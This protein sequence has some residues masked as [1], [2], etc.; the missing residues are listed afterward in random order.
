M[1]IWLIFIILFAIEIASISEEIV[2]RMCRKGMLDFLENVIILETVGENEQRAVSEIGQADDL[3]NDFVDG[4]FTR[5][6]GSVVFLW[7]WFWLQRNS[8]IFFRLSQ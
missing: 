6:Q 5:I 2:D 1:R 3:L 8:M 7:V 4:T